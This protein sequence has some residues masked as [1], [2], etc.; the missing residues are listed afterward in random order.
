M[1]LEDLFF[2]AITK[3][4]EILFIHLLY[5]LVQKASLRPRPG[6]NVG[7]EIVQTSRPNFR[8]EVC[9]SLHPRQAW[10]CVIG[11]SRLRLAVDL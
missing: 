8:F 7:V 4:E 11:C 1:D 5:E 2:Q 9:T 10:R 3:K 6:K